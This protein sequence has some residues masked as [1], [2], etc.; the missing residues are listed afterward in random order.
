MSVKDF[1]ELNELPFNNSPDIRFFYKSKEHEEAIIR[2]KYGVE[3]NKGLITIVGPIGTG[4]TTLARLILDELDNEKNEVALIVV[5]H[6]E[7]TSEWILRKLNMQLGVEN[8]P[9]DKP[10]MLSSLYQ[11]LSV[12]TG[13]GKRVV[14]LIDE[15]QMLKKKEVME[16]LRGILNFE[17]DT[18]KL[19][20]FVL[21]GLPELEDNLMLDEPLR[22]RVAMRFVLKP[23]DLESTINY[24]MHRLKVAGA[25][26]PIFTLD[27]IKA[28]YKYSS[29]IP[30]VINTI[31]D[32]SMFEAYLLKK[33]RI[34][35]ELIEQ[36]ATD[37]GL[38]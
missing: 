3:S 4:K 25:K 20:N 22:Q 11:R 8:V 6:S 5:V 34:E 13:E 37:L 24:I 30:R 27:A 16:E 28:V 32:N 15:A 2:I 19:I 7:V 35:K 14:I 1:F 36:V 17:D 23:F 31:C 10:S 38:K 12:L 18:G 33:K 21:F 29:G 26:E 9:E